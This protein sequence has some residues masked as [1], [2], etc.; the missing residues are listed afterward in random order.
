MSVQSGSTFSSSN[1]TPSKT[2]ESSP[3]LDLFLGENVHSA[4]ATASEF[5][6]RLSFPSV[7]FLFFLCA[8]FLNGG[9][10]TGVLYVRYCNIGTAC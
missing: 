4:L 7:R 10:N 6:S 1:V 8:R 3:R 9:T 2:N 5:L